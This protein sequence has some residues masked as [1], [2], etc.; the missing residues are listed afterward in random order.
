MAVHSSVMANHG[1]T[2]HHQT[3]YLLKHCTEIAYS[4]EAAILA[5]AF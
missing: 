5:N 4:L 3:N 2:Y 1:F